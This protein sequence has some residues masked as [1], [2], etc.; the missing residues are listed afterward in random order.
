MLTSARSPNAGDISG[1][2]VLHGASSC[3]PTGF[4]TRNHVLAGRGSIRLVFGKEATIGTHLKLGTQTLLNVG[5][6]IA[7]SELHISK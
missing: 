3:N 4:S 6:G 2:L 5:C 1:V 7:L